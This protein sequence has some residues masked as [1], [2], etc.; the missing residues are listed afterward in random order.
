MKIKNFSIEIDNYDNAAM[1]EMQ[2]QET[3]R[4]LEDCIKKIKWHDIE[5]ETLLRD[6]NGNK[7]GR[8]FVE[9]E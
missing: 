5:G 6:I 2:L 1:S 7:V 9:T 3:I 8:M 4:I